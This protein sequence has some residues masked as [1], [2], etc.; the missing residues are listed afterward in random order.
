MG[1][2]STT[3]SIVL[4]L[5]DEASGALKSTA[6]GL[7]SWLRQL[8]PAFKTIAVASGV[9][10]GALSGEIYLATDA[11]RESIKIH[12]QLNAVLASTKGAAGVTAE[13]ADRLANAMQDVTNYDNDAVLSMENIL[14]TFTKINKD[15][16][17]ETTQLTLDMAT[18]MH[19]DL[20][21]A[22][23]QV[24]KALQDPVLG[25]TTLRRVGV[26]FT[27]DQI[28]VV[29]ELVATGQAA[30]AQAMILNELQ[31]EFGGSAKAAADPVI[32]LQNAVSDLQ[33]EIG[34]ALIPVLN[35][36][37]LYIRPVIEHVMRWVD[38]HPKLTA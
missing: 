38:A 5:I 35:D 13:A 10:F 8:E 18:A 29:K 7:D 19:E 14:L 25:M 4:K 12:N 36:L 2:S 21:E 23:I 16:F 17:P 6:S 28:K 1:G 24:G 9:A 32:Q 27:E 11:A 33:K 26:S 30:K 20:K 34:K 3:L 37:V 31:R 15:I 22:A